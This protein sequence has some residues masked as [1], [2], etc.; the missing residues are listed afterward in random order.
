MTLLL[1]SRNCNGAKVKGSVPEV[2]DKPQ[3]YTDEVVC[4]KTGSPLVPI[5]DLRPSTCSQVCLSP[6]P[7]TPQMDHNYIED[8]T[9]T[10]GNQIK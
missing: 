9:Y 6:P 7:L 10:P 1:I 3:I 5:T 4:D 8:K 2:N